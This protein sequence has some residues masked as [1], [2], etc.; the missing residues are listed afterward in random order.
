MNYKT[1]TLLLFLGL[2]HAVYGQ[3]YTTNFT[4]GYDAGIFTEVNTLGPNLALKNPDSSGGNDFLNY[5]TGGVA[6]TGFEQV[7]LNYGGSSPLVPDNTENFAVS[8]EVSNFAGTT[9][10]TAGA[11]AFA[12]IGLNIN[13]SD[14]VDGFKLYNGAYYF[15][16][17]GS[18]DMIFFD[19]TN[20]AQALD[21]STAATVLTEFSAA[22]QTF[23]FSYATAAS[24][25]GS[26]VSFAT[27]NINGTGTTSG[28]NFVEDWGMASGTSFDIN[29]YAGSNVAIANEAAGFGYMNADNFFL[30]VVPEP[31]SYAALLGMFAMAAVILR[32]RY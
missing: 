24:T 13:D 25:S 5:H 6:P 12:Q 10:L 28:S 11:N 18:S 23:T 21:F 8:V 2:A 16:G 7:F 29:I 26:F 14:L 27:L 30:N 15:N 32:R 4:G 19:G 31:S 22:T 9:G 17:F 1:I 3:V 20:F